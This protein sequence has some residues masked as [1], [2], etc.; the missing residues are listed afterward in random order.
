MT[1]L[2]TT[3]GSLNLSLCVDGIAK[4]YYINNTVRSCALILVFYD[5]MRATRY[6]T[7]WSYY[8]YMVSKLT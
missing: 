8:N 1:G 4:Y 5:V 2:L 3:P 7:T 6:T